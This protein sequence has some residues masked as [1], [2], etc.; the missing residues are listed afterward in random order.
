MIN[1]L[2]EIAIKKQGNKRKLGIALGFDEK[3]AGQRVDKLIKNQN[4]KLDIF[5]KLLSTAELLQILELAI[6][7][8]HQKINKK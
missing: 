3:Y 8:E 4:F 2:I 6:A 5:K 1:E 7:A